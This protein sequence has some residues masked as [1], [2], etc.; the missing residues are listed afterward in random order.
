MVISSVLPM[1][2]YRRIKTAV[3]ADE[4]GVLNEASALQTKEMVLG[5]GDS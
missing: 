4:G 5:S 3:L 1:L 2:E